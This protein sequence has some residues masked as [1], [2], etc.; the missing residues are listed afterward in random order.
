MRGHWTNKEPMEVL[1]GLN[2]WLVILGEENPQ[3]SNA[4]LEQ[5]AE[6]AMQVLIAGAKNAKELQQKPGLRQTLAAFH[7]PREALR[8]PELRMAA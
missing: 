2:E 8:L 7:V 5:A 6:S 1:R 4:E 3:A